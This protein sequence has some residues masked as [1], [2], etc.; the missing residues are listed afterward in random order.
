MAGE[1]DY[2]KKLFLRLNSNGCIELDGDYLWDGC[3]TPEIDPDIDLSPVPL[4]KLTQLLCGLYSDDNEKADI[5]R[6]KKLA[7]EIDASGDIVRQLI[8]TIE[9]K[10][11]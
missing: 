9:A 4:L 1:T 2:T 5:K 8:K 3:D 6:F 11:P 10:F 7:A